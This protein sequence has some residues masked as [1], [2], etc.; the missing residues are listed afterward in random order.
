VPNHGLPW[1]SVAVLGDFLPANA[2]WTPDAPALTALSV[3]DGR[4]TISYAEFEERTARLACGLIDAGV[5]KGDR[6]A[7]LLNNTAG[8]EGAVAYAAIHRAGAI[9]LPINGRFVPREA[10]ALAAHS[11]IRVLIYEA[12]FAPHADAVLEAC[13]PAPVLILVSEERDSRALPWSEPAGAD[14]DR[15]KLP[16]V[17]PGDLCAF[18]YTS[19]TT[20]LPKCVMLTHHNCVAAA[21]MLGRCFRM[22]S[23]DVHFTPFP[24]YTSS[25]VHT[26]LLS[27]FSSGG[28]YYMSDNTR[29]EDLLPEMEEAGTTVF[30]AVPAI[31][32][33]LLQ[34]P[35][36]ATTDLT[37]V[38]MA[39]HAGAAVTAPLVGRIMSAFPR[40]E[41]LNAFGQ[42]ESGN[43]GTQL[44]GKWA[45]RKAGSIGYEGMPGVLV[46]VVDD[47]DE[48]VK[49][50]GV[51]EIL[52]K[53]EAVMQGY[54]ENP[55]A[56]SET[57]QG[58][59]LRTGDLVRVDDDGFWYV[60]DRKKDMIIRGG[61]NIASLEVEAAVAEHPSVLES[62]VVGIPH[63]DLGEDLA[64]F[65]V[66]TDGASLEAEELRDFL[67]ERLADYK[68]PRI[69][70]F[71]AELRRNPTGKILKRDLRETAVARQGVAA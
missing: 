11:R 14:A 40:A 43:P 37:S 68:I 66:L 51:G 7:F 1:D 15:Q 31:Y 27:C 16:N 53:S 42:T 18:L 30:G 22:R 32:S 59:W 17:E 56:T 71:V 34:S 46:K 3:F 8:I 57:L 12:A 13:H 38:R 26:S 23:D 58:G 61:H 36:M 65:V 64:M 6:V 45:L 5:D 29:A 4:V 55:E 67:K 41:V 20:G 10:A 33:F 69:Y 49:R 50:D 60:Y 19:G 35:A 62:A 48:E 52:L 21:F 25:G 63:K 47:S 9:A 24:F 39:W 54:F 70:H 44:P 28:H 2:A